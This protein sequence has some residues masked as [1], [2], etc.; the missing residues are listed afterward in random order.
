MWVQSGCREGA[1][2]GMW[3]QSGC[4]IGAMWV[5]RWCYVG[6]RWV[7]SGCQVGAKWYLAGI[8]W[9]FFGQVKVFLVGEGLLSKSI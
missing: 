8:W 4:Y 7:Q 5:L 6:A 3:V 2:E 1:G 9:V